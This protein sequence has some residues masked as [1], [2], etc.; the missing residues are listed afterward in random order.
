MAKSNVHERFLK[1]LTIADTQLAATVGALHLAMAN[2]KAESLSSSDLVEETIDRVRA[3]RVS[4]LEIRSL[5]ESAAA[6]KAEETLIES[7]Q[8]PAGNETR[9]KVKNASESPADGEAGA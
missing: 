8:E 5:S 6:S 9:R 3:V 4:I 2:S 7:L 1:S